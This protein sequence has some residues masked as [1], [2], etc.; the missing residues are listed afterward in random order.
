MVVNRTSAGLAGSS[1]GVVMTAVS[2]AGEEGGFVVMMRVGSYSR[3]S[4]VMSAPSTAGW[5]ERHFR[6]Q[7]LLYAL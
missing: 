6:V 5:E 4:R 1:S 3:C 7:S 2:K